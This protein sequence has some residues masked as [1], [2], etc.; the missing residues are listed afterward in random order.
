M[1]K[2]RSKQFNGMFLK[3]RESRADQE[4]NWIDRV[5]QAL[6]GVKLIWEEAQ[7]L[8]TNSAE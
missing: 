5:K 1:I 4:K 7:Q 3:R 8:A 2:V 6:K